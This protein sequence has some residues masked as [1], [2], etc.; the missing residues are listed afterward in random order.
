MLSDFEVLQMNE[1]YMSLFLVFNFSVIHSRKS[2]PR[3][4]KYIKWDATKNE[5]Y[6]QIIQAQQDTLLNI[7]SDLTCETDVHSAVRELTLTIYDSVF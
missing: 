3:I 1:S 2:F 7:V 4:H 5:Q 6:F